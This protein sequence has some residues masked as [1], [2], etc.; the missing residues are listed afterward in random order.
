MWLM[1]GGLMK[2]KDTKKKKKEKSMLY[3][4][5][6]WKRIVHVSKGVKYNYYIE[7]DL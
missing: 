3:A 2:M 5:I 7:V 1:R 6:K 4:Q